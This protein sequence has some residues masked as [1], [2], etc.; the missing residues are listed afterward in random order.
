VVEVH[1]ED[2]VDEEMG[3]QHY[4]LPLDPTVAP[5]IA[6]SNSLKNYGQHLSLCLLLV[7]CIPKDDSGIAQGPQYPSIT[8]D[9]SGEC[10]QG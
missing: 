6:L 4:L 8:P 3:D 10:G 1:E 2:S 5:Y 9:T 7:T